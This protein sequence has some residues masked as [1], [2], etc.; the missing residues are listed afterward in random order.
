MRQSYMK[1]NASCFEELIEKYNPFAFKDAKGEPMLF[2]DYGK[3]YEYLF[4]CLAEE[5]P[6]GYIDLPL[7][8]HKRTKMPLNDCKHFIGTWWKR[9]EVVHLDWTY[10]PEVRPF[11]ID[12]VDL[13][14]KIS[15]TAIDH[16]KLQMRLAVFLGEIKMKL[17]KA[18]AQ[19]TM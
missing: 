1:I 15:E 7:F 13:F 17:N 12:L 18:G 5:C 8:M 2:S 4:K 6:V 11:L 16:E 19:V 10:F 14:H 9:G 3:I